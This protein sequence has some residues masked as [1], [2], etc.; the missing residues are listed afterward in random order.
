MAPGT[1]NA[2]KMLALINGQRAAVGAPPVQL[3]AALAVAAQRHSQDQGDHGR[4]SHT[5]SDGSSLQQRAES[6]GYHGWT[7]LGENVA[8]GQHSIDQ[9]MAD[10]MASPGHRANIL[11]PTY[12]SV[13]FGLAKGATW[14][15]D[16][17]RSGTC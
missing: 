7:A 11:N 17:G 16:F 5:G 10:W 15:Q 2:N 8:M 9:V 14:T 1:A 4:I 6:A 12:T 13:G 3:C